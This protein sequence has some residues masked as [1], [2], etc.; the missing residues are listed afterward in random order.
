LADLDGGRA[1]AVALSFTFTFTFTLSFAFTFTF[2]FAF[3]FT[4]ALS[5]AFTDVVLVDA[6]ALL[7]PG[8]DRAHLTGVALIVVFAGARPAAEH[9]AER[10]QREQRGQQGMGA[11]KVR[12]SSSFIAP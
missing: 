11:R 10:A 2:A 4:F 8:R 1:R 3:A 7:L 5:F 12:H 6:G 9:T